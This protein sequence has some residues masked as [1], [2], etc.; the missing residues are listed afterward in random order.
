MSKRDPLVRLAHMRD[1]ATKAHT[2]AANK[3]REDLQ[4]DE[5]LRLALTHLIELV[6]EAASK[7]PQK[8]RT[9][10]PEIPWSDIVGIRNR[11]IHGYDYVDYDILWS[12]ITMD[13]PPLIAEL[14][15]ILPAPSPGEGAGASS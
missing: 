11:L 7:V 6:G 12:V 15:K 1:F 3:T 8:L 5:V 14:K 2:L 10:Y 9:A 13:L 4:A